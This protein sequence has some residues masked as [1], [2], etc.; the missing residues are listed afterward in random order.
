MAAAVAI[1]VAAD[2]AVVLKHAAV[3][4]LSAADCIAFA[5]MQPEAYWLA[6]TRKMPKVQTCC[7]YCCSM[8]R[9]D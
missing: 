6:T 9:W 7:C 1:A 3:L 5:V 4:G 8:E 2:F